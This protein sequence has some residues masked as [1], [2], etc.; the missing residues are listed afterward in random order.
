M[1]KLICNVLAYLFL[2]NPLM[3]STS[4]KVSTQGILDKDLVPMSLEQ[5]KQKVADA[6]LTEVEQAEINNYIDFAVENKIDPAQANQELTAMM[7]NISFTGASFDS[8]AV[9]YTVLIV[10][11]VAVVIAAAA[12][13]GSGGGGSSS[14]WTCYA[15]SPSYSAVGTGSTIAIAQDVALSYC[16]ANSYYWETCYSDSYEC[17]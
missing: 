17:Y 10:A 6:G 1:K 15:D 14:Y 8:E 5:V 16:A 4:S 2:I 7:K 11:I 13:G 12:N 3:A 9:L